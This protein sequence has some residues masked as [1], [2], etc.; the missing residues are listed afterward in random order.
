MHLL[1]KHTFTYRKNT[2]ILNQFNS[3]F[4]FLTLFF[5]IILIQSSSVASSVYDQGFD[6]VY[7]ESN[8][9][10]E[11]PGPIANFGCPWPNS[12]G[13]G[14]I[15]KEDKCPRMSGTKKNKGCLKLDSKN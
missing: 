11:Y 4:K 14:I 15:N 5:L 1:N 6:G 13:D 10:I 8:L 7:V 3:Y 2:L 9:C 12:D